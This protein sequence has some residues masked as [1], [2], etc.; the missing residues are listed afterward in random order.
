MTEENLQETSENKPERDEKGRLLPG[1]TAN[2]AGRPPGTISITA[3]IKK[4]LEEEYSN[5]DNPEERKLYLEKIIEA[6][7]H[8]AIELKDAR[9]LKD[10]WSYIDGQPKATLD[11]GADKDSLE[12]LTRFFKAMANPDDTTG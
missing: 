8:N 10:I 4:K 6:I 12:E 1:N 2:P 7:F 5:K 3:A 11:I 9:T